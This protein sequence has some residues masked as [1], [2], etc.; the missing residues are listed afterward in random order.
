M[1]LVFNIWNGIFISQGVA[2]G[3]W[4]ISENLQIYRLYSNIIAVVLNISVNLLLIPKYGI[5][6]AAMATLMTQALGTW[7]VSLF[8][9]PLRDS[10]LDMIRSVNPLYL[11]NL[12]N[13]KL[14]A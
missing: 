4:M 7:V 3:I 9:K 2:R 6:G 1:A 13:D 5:V 10:T 12:K 11:F 14:N 8:W